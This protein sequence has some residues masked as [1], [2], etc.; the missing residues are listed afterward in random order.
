MLLIGQ[1]VI[2]GLPRPVVFPTP[3][4]RITT[5]LGYHDR[6]EVP[7]A[8]VA[9]RWG[10]VYGPAQ[11]PPYTSKYP[12]DP[13]LDYL[14][15]FLYA[16]LVL[17]GQANAPFRAAFGYDVIKSGASLFPHN[18]SERVFSASYLPALYCWRDDQQ[19]GKFEQYGDDW[20]IERSTWTLL[21]ALPLGDQENQRARTQYANQFVKSVVMGIERSYT[22]SWVLP[23]DPDRDAQQ[24]GSFLGY[25]TNAVRFWTTGWRRTKIRVQMAD[26]TPAQDF[27]AVELKLEVTERQD[28]TIRRF[29]PVN[30]LDAT[31][32][33]QF[34]VRVGHEI[35]T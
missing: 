13:A 4:P 34:G 35:D 11:P 18:P 19:G 14:L 10:T 20:L 15:G 16:W 24:R 22:P 25:W 28:R 26:N 33:N 21:W 7:G 31:Y 32:L 3:P 17:D 27:P 6:G 1:T 12:G 23:G 29:Q 9:D 30:Y 5:P 2:S 8:P